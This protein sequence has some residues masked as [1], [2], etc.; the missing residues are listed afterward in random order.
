MS[1]KGFAL[2]RKISRIL[3]EIKKPLS[4][5]IPCILI[6]RDFKNIFHKQSDLLSFSISGYVF[7]LLPY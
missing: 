7:S 1:V 4:I 6:T 5:I 3:M 2:I